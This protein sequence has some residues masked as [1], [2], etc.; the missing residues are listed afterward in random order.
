MTH[1]T[2]EL[3]DG[4]PHIYRKGTYWVIK[5]KVNS[6]SKVDDGGTVEDLG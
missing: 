5:R 4:Q 2:Q 6:S 1:L 3:T